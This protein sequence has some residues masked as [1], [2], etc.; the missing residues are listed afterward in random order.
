MNISWNDIQGLD[1]QGR[2][3]AGKGY[4]NWLNKKAGIEA[5]SPNRYRLPTE[6]EWELAARAG[7]DGQW[8]LGRD[9]LGVLSEKTANYNATQTHANSVKGQ[10]RQQTVPV[11]SFEP[12]KWGLY[13]MH[14]N[15]WEWV[16][17][18]YVE[19]E[20]ERR[21]GANGWNASQ[22]APETANCPRVLRGGSWYYFPQFLRS[23]FRF[24]NSPGDRSI[25]FGFRLA[26]TLP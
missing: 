24:S 11:K 7:S 2:V 1:N 19:N 6:A 16:Q 8:S 14:G 10:F 25:V 23:A 3:E 20:Y 18:C 15:V 26:R 12:N 21:T 13:D 17:D 22:T 4:L 5:N 9:N